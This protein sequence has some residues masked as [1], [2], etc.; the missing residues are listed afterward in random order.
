MTRSTETPASKPRSINERS[1][2]AQLERLRR[3]TV[4]EKMELLERIS[5]AAR[6]MQRLA[7]KKRE[8]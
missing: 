8:Q 6:E 4:L 1:K 2:A 3:A 5:A 7:S